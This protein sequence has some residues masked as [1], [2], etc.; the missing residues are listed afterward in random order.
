MAWQPAQKLSGAFAAAREAVVA[1][2][3][4]RKRPGKSYEGFMAALQQRSG[5]LL[6]R[7]TLT[8]RGI[9]QCLGG[10]SWRWREWV[11]MAVDGSRV[12]TPRTAANEDAFGCAGKKRTAPQMLL[13]T[14]FHLGQGLPWSWRRG[15]GDGSEREDLRRM[16]PTLP[17]RTLLLADAGF[18]GYDLLRELLQAGH[19]F[20]VR[21]GANVHLLRELGYFTREYDGIVYLWPRSKRK[22]EPLVLRLVRIRTG[23]QDVCLLTNVLERSKLSDR[24]VAELYRRRWCIEVMFRTLKETM[25]NRKM[26]SGSPD[27]ARMELDWAMMGLWLLGLMTAEQMARKGRVVSSWSP[28]KALDVVQEAMRNPQKRRPAGGVRRQ[29]ESAVKDSYRRAGPKAA[30]D[31]PHKKTDKPPGEPEIRTANRAE[32]QRAQ[33]LKRSKTAA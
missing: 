29:L 1:M 21:V 13:T 14:I 32:T 17:K 5:D 3:S 31:W 26:H 30:R 10:A 28:A 25:S 33:R 12:N 23:R 2:Y 11:V 4:T 8:L 6:T 15:R 7:I 18:T 27:N 19:D 16:I 24:K 22:E 20:I 9:M